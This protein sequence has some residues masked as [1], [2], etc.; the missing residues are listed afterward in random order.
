MKRST[1]FIPYFIY[2]WLNAKKKMSFI[3]KRFGVAVRWPQHTSLHSQKFT[4]WMSQPN[5]ILSATIYICIYLYIA[6]MHVYVCVF[7]CI[8]MGVCICQEVMAT[9][10]QF[11]SKESKK[12]CSASND[13]SNSNNNNNSNNGGKS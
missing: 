9:V 12:Y 7:V 10:R 3:I 1:Q 4:Y 13:S 5:A 2:K 6:R 8:C 11:A